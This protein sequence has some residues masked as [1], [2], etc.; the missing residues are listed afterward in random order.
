MAP[1]ESQDRAG[2]EVEGLMRYSVRLR[3]GLPQTVQIMAVTSGGLPRPL[4]QAGRRRI[5]HLAP[6]CGAFVRGILVPEAF[7]QGR[8]RQE[9][10]PIT[11]PSTPRCARDALL[12]PRD[13]L[14]FYGRLHG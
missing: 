3:L 1:H 6:G 9:R 11:P 2:Q 14:Q 4:Q 12:H 5:A 7:L 13:L 10:T 8:E